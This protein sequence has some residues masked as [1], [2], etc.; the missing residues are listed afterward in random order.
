M[1][2]QWWDFGPQL[3]LTTFFY[4]DNNGLNAHSGWSHALLMT[5]PDESPD[6]HLYVKVHV[7]IQVHVKLQLNFIYL[8]KVQLNLHMNL[9]LHMKVHVKVHRKVHN[10]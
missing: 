10:A 6:H 3:T 2:F 1:L 9:L 4:W 7:K 8:V 5:Y